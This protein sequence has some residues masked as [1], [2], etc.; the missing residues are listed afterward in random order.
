MKNKKLL[1]IVAAATLAV[2][3]ISAFS[4]CY[5]SVPA[6]MEQ[7][8]GTYKLTKY[9]YR[10]E[11]EEE[12]HDYIAEKQ[13]VAYLVVG[14]EG[15]GYYVYGDKDTP[16]YAEEVAIT[17]EYETKDSGEKDEN[18]NPVMTR[19]D[20]IKK[21]RYTYGDEERGG[22]PNGHP[23]GGWEDL[24]FD[25]KN[26]NLNMHHSPYN[27]LLIKIKTY[28]SVE[29]TR[30]DRSTAL[31]AVEKAVNETFKTAPYMMKRLNGKFVFRSYDALGKYDGLY[32]VDI[33]VYNMKATVTAVGSD[34]EKQVSENLTVSYEK[35]GSEEMPNEYALKIGEETYYSYYSNNLVFTSFF[36]KNA[37]GSTSYFYKAEDEFDLDAEIRAIRGVG[38]DENDEGG[39]SA[40]THGQPVEPI[41]DGGTYTGH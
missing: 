16:M 17:Y 12:D 41:T 36:K 7:L 3:S 40:A 28:Q 2:G 39:E 30:V 14:S 20:N 23:G 25:A 10:Q 29:Y 24:G 8:V 31:S 33:D 4:G 15:T 37:D 13:I 21:I 6:P 34:G 27:G 32:V 11:T 1:S 18:G 38:G 5:K 35:S 22:G 19:T 9:T 26:K